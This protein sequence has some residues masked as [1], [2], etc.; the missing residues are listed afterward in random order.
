MKHF[1]YIKSSN[2]DL[3]S[4]TEFS[5]APSP[6]IKK[7]LARKEGKALPYKTPL[8]VG[9]CFMVGKTRGQ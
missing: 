5:A 7:T 6:A 1:Y 3:L 2:F 9:E 4:K 8:G